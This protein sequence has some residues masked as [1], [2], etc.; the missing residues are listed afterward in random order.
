[1]NSIKFVKI[2]IF[3]FA[4][5]TLA[6]AG[7]DAQQ[8]SAPAP[9][10]LSAPA[11][12]ETV[13]VLVG[14]SIVINVQ[15]PLTRVLSSNSEAVETMATSPTQVVVEGKAAGASSLVLWGKDGHS[16]VLDVVADIDIAGLRNVIQKTYPKEHIDIEADGPHLLLTGTASNPHIV[17]DLG[18]M[19][20]VYSKEVVNSIVVPLAHDRQVLLEVKFAEVDR[21]ALS[22]LGVNLFSTGAANTLGVTTTGQFGSFGQEKLTDVIGVRANPQPDVFQPSLGSHHVPFKSETDINQVLNLFLFRP[23][24]HLGAVIQAL[25]SQN[26]LQILAEPNLM[27]LS[28]QKATFLAG[29]EFPFPVVQ[30]S[31]GFSSISILF[32]PFGVK[33][34]F[35][36]FVADDN[37]LR[38]H[39]APE[40][41]ALDFT[42]AVTLPG[43]GTVPAISTRRAETEIELKDGQSFGIAGLLDQRATTLL[44]KVPGIGDI[45]VLGQLFRSRSVNKTNNELLVFVTPHIL[46]PVRTVTVAPA[47]PV[48]P[49]PFLDKTSFDKQAPGNKASENKQTSDKPQASTP[50]GTKTK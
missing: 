36:G 43:G 6:F 1:M 12:G 35:T 20:G 29:G 40:V 30:P 8:S 32:K 15:E 37:T 48:M 21:S 27:A 24:L 38:L 47:V 23:D 3:V 31:A 17:D 13:H 16:Q 5:G 26:I 41:S 46:D 11:E 28:G 45:P 49:V 42:N 25:Q 33:L 19:A 14:K 7:T 4:L 50:E 9:P 10:Q 18:K 44:S 2:A 39:V 22:Q 34:D